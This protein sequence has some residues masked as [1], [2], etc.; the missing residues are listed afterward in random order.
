MI[1]TQ[2]SNA[3]PPAERK[4]NHMNIKELMIELD[5]V[6]RNLDRIA[7][8]P[9]YIKQKADEIYKGKSYKTDPAAIQAIVDECLA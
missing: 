2:T 3:G 8:D 5:T 6:N 4:G 9:E 1:K 7:N